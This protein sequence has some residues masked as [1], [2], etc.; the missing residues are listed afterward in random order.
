MAGDRM[1]AAA[2]REQI[3][4]VAREC[5]TERGFL[6]TTTAMIAQRAQVT[7][8]I[9][10][11]HFSSKLDLFHSI[12]EDTRGRTLGHFHEVSERCTTGAERLLAIVED[13]PRFARRNRRFLDVVDRVAAV[14]N[15]DKTRKLLRDYF[16]GFEDALASFIEEGQRDGSIRKTLDVRTLAAFLTMAGVGFGVVDGVHDRMV[17]GPDFPKRLVTLLQQM[18][19]KAK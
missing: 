7:E 9:L 8:P 3:I 5:F 12:L 19:A 11:R 16:A 2:R 10:Y 1:K 15:T 18:L 14:D 13:Y 17:D 6:G 4:N